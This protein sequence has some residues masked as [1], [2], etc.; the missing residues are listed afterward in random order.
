VQDVRRDD[1]DNID[2]VLARRLGLCH[3]AI[4]GVAARGIESQV[5]ARFDRPLRIGAERAGDQLIAVV[6]PRSNPVRLADEGAAPASNHAQAQPGRGESVMSSR[7][8]GDC[9]G[10]P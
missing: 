9:L 5:A 1:A 8:I 3:F 6:E 10:P 4:I 7:L 2:A